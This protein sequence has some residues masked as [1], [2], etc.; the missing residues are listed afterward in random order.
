MN[1]T[2]CINIQYKVIILDVHTGLYGRQN[3]HMVVLFNVPN[4]DIW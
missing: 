1:G 2:Y 3:R 4:S